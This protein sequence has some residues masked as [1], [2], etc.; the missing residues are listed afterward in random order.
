M[1]F[2]IEIVDIVMKFIHEK[3]Y[4]ADAFVGAMAATV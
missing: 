2:G 3:P 1:E 4:G